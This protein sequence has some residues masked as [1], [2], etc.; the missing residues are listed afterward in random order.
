M[1]KLIAGLFV[2]MIVV[3]VLLAILDRFPARQKKADE[4]VVPGSKGT[5]FLRSGA[6]IEV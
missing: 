5:A 6:G 3:F 4:G 1:R 2:G